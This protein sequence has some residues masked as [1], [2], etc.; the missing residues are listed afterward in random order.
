MRFTSFAFSS[1]L[2]Y[3]RL[4]ME[5]VIPERLMYFHQIAVFMSWLRNLPLD[6][7]DKRELLLHWC[8]I[9]G[10]KTTGYMLEWSGLK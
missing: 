1:P 2:R 7:E 8:D 4:T 6:P 9:V 5:E 10:V 3:N